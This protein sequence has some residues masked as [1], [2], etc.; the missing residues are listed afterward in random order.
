MA[1]KHP[2]KFPFPVGGLDEAQAYTSQPPYTSP[3]LQNVRAFDTVEE[4]WRGGQRPGLSKGWEQ[5][6]GGGEPI[7]Y[8]GQVTI[9]ETSGAGDATAFEW[10]DDFMR[11]GDVSDSADWGDGQ[12]G[13]HIDGDQDVRSPRCRT[14]R[15][16]LRE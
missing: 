5:Q 9:V 3:D 11:D 6:L 15:L 1:K 12:L 2:I 8:M 16:C 7:Y 13:R 10:T 4:R 14:Q